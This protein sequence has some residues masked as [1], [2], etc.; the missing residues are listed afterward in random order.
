MSITTYAS[1][2]GIPINRRFP[3]TLTG[4]A[5]LERLGRVRGYPNLLPVMDRGPLVTYH[6]SM[7]PLSAIVA[8]EDTSMMFKLG[9]FD[10]LS[11]RSLVLQGLGLVVVAAVLWGYL[12]P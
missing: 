9:A 10:G 5:S 11:P 3:M 8:K 7:A 6:S 4:G 1:Q 12:G 2:L